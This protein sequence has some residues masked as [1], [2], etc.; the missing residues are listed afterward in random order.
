MYVSPPAPVLLT[1]WLTAESEAQSS[2]VPTR[3]GALR[4]PLAKPRNWPC[5]QHH[6]EP[7]TLM[8]QV[9]A[10]PGSITSHSSGLPI[11]WGSE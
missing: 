5:P 7:P 8:P 6:S 10:P 2:S 4:L 9:C 1:I 3:T 11:G